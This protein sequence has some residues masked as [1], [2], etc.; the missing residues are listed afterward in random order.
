[1]SSTDHIST[2]VATKPTANWVTNAT[3][4]WTRRRTLFRVG[5]VSL[6][7]S[8]IIAFTI[9]KQYQSTARLMPPEQGSSG[10]A[11]LAALAGRSL[12]GLG[13]LGSLAGS[14]LG[15]KSSSALYIDLLHS[16]AI[17]DRIID[18]FNLQHVYHKRYRID[19]VKYL[20]RHTKVEEDKKSGVV[21]LTFTD[22]NAERARAIAA[23]YIEE[24]NNLLTHTSVSSARQEREFI[25]KRL[26]T[27]QDSLLTAEKAMSDFSSVNT[28]L[29]IKEQTRAMVDAGSKLQAEMIV[30]QSELASLKQIYGD[31]NVRVRAARARIADLQ[32]ELQKMSGSSAEVP[33]RDAKGDPNT[34][35]LY[36]SLRQIPRLAVPY[37]N[38][39]RDV[40]IQET[41]F[42]LLSQQYELARIEEAK[43]TPVVSVFE[44]PLLAEKKSFPPRVPMM[45]LLTIFFVGI[46]ATILILQ[47]SWEQVAADDPRKVLVQ[48]IAASIRA[49]T[50]G[51]IP[52]RRNP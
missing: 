45:L 35:S 44:Q 43:D 37:A 29:D 42:E 4:L 7:L 10:A 31:D 23:A 8:G 1:M 39:Y 49:R 12:G 9:P 6:V 25:E 27:V 19:T 52:E 32:G 20:V 48:Q 33:A 50:P 15:A 11:M 24:L 18:R 14:L 40:R 41:V 36:P 2:P 38:L 21:T 46:A 22:T 5:V 34:S 30:G 13:G 17:N 3:F 51:F 47:N 28:T 16:R 26:V